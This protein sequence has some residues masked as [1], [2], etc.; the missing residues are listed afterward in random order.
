MTQQIFNSTTPISGINA[1]QN[2]H[3]AIYIYIYHHCVELQF[4]VPNLVR[5]Q[6]SAIN[7]SVFVFNT[8]GTRGKF[9]RCLKRTLR[10]LELYFCLQVDKLTEDEIAGKKNTSVIKYICK[11]QRARLL[12]AVQSK[13]LNSIIINFSSTYISNCDS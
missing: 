10:I 4:P 3:P 12:I 1:R 13:Q 2:L 6:R 8:F 11:G 7:I 5:S 9:F